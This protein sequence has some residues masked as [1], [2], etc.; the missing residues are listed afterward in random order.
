[1]LTDPDLVH[2]DPP[3]RISVN[4][5]S[6]RK[7]WRN[8]IE[9]FP[10]AAYEEKTTRVRTPVRDI[11]FVCDPELIEDIL[12]RRADTFGRDVIM[13][14]AFAPFLGKT[15]IFLAEGAHWRWQRRAAAPIFRNEIL[16]SFVPV[17][18]EMAARQISRWQGSGDKP[19]EVSAG[20]FRTTFDVIMETML[21][22]SAALNFARCAQALSDALDAASWHYLLAMFAAPAW[23]PFPGRRRVSKAH[24]YFYREI[25]KV[26]TARAAKAGS[27]GD[28]IDH[29]IAAR[30]SETGRSMTSAEIVMNLLSF[31]N[32]GHETTT[33]ALTWTLWLIARS[34]VLQQQLCDEVRTVA[35]DEAIAAAH[36]E[37]L[38][39]CRR[40]IQESMRLYP[41]VPA[42]G[43][44]ATVDTR[45]G[46]HDLKASTQIV[47][48]IFALHRHVRL[49]ENPNTFDLDRFA[50]E[51]AKERARCAYLP[52]GA[53]PRVCIG[54]SFAM[55]EAVVI[56]A[57][58]VRAFRFRAVP[59]FRP[60]PLARISLR[61][62]GG[63]PL[64]IQRR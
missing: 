10:R 34:E 17:F 52:F 31:I 49:W 64:F 41:P 7:V 13:R 40:A 20:M 15:S 59:E 48:P 50:P 6:L 19:I 47:L 55:I 57:T 53:G 12:I 45:V 16:L 4:F 37:R 23:V 33:A 32:A 58:L 29:L 38:E 24:D 39:C 27:R 60:K 5:S 25:D 61:P 22:G 9:T 42:L 14:R 28:L 3:A 63:I 51:Q 8:I 46:E 54:A 30:D 1:M 44:R 2:F 36:V 43:R 26:V 35:G 56:L 11:L 21:G 62:Q 18:A